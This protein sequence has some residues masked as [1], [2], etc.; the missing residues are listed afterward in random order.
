M[1]L[2]ATRSLLVLGL[3]VL[4]VVVFAYM[5]V[6]RNIAKEMQDKALVSDKKRFT[7]NESVDIAMAMKLI[8]HE[9]PKMLNPPNE[10]P[11]LLLYPPSEE[12]LARLSGQ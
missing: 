2:R 12:E 4:L 1:K 10:M 3:V 9:P 7:P 6:P 5:M 8:T 11:P